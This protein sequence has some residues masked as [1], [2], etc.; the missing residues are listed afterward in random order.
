M[1]KVDLGKVARDDHLRVP[2]HAGKEHPDLCRRR[3]LR[4]IEDDDRIAQRTS[5]H[6]SQGSDLDDVPVHHVLQLYGG[7]HVLQ[8]IIERLQVRVDLVFHVTRKE[9]ELLTGFYSRTREDDLLGGLLLERLHRQGY[10][11]IGLPRS[12]RTDGEN[13]VVLLEGVDQLLLIPRPPFDRPSRY[14]ID[15]DILYRIGLGLPTFHDV[16]DI[17]F[18]QGVIPLHMPAHGLDVLLYLGHLLFVA[19]DPD[20]I[21]TRDNPQLGEERLDHLKMAVADSIEDDRVYIFKN[22]MLLYQLR[23]LYICSQ[24]YY[25][26]V[27]L[28]NYSPKVSKLNLSAAQSTCTERVVPPRILRMILSRR[29]LSRLIAAVE[30]PVSHLPP[31]RKEEPDGYYATPSPVSCVNAIHVA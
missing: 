12:G 15:K 27:T 24:S 19:Q 29:M 18:R 11:E 17:L 10:A 7:N 1:G 22:Y 21:V 25:K 23:Q 8:R 20:D 4:F 14:R 13:H 6:K 16:K 3:V 28:A 5:P 2:A 26:I 9:A 30:K 31:D